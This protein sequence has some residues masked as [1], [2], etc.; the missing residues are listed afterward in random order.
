MVK[1]VRI[2]IFRKKPTILNGMLSFEEPTVQNQLN[3][4]NKLLEDGYT[5]ILKT[6][7]PDPLS[8]N[9]LAVFILYKP[10]CP[11]KDLSR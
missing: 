1:L 3:A 7:V 2:P 9:V 4:L 10:D 5:P 8:L 11:P 6:L